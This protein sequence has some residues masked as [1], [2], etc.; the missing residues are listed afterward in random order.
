MLSSVMTLFGNIEQGAY[1]AANAY[2]ESLAHQRY[3]AGLPA[4]TVQLGAV[5]GAGVLHRNQR[6]CE[7]VKARGLLPLHVDNIFSKL[8]VLMTQ[9]EV[10]VLTMS[11]T[12]SSQT[13][14]DF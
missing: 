6:T 13:V 1:V 2:L 9:K 14:K 12:V 10:P 7:I 8:D 11:N 3:T 4:L 5:T